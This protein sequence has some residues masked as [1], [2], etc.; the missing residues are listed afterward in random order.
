VLTAADKLLPDGSR[1]SDY[2]D[3]PH[4][5]AI[6]TADGY[7]SLQIYRG[8]RSKFT[9]GDKLKGTPQEYRDASLGMSVHFGRYTLDPAKNTITFQIDRSAFPN[10][11]DTT[12]VSAYEM[13]GD[14]L[15]WKGAPVRTAPSPSPC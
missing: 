5:L 14:V 4:G 12:R 6:F 3:H 2:G 9:S 10:W 1:A 8:D 13:K 7:Y 15:C 11:D